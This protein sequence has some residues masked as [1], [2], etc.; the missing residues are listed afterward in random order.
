[1]SAENQVR[2]NR[3]RVIGMVVSDRMDKTRVVTVTEHYKHPVYSKFVKRT[4]K[5]RMHD[6]RNDSK[7]GD[8]VEIIETRPLSKTKRW[9]LTRVIERA[10]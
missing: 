6:E 1:M 8:K 3:K 5:Y 7:R 10:V 4:T 2:G 9:R